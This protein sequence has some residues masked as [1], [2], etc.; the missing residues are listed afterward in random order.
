[1]S[2]EPKI[3]QSMTAHVNGGNKFS[4]LHYDIF[5]DGKPTGISRFV[6]TDG[7]PDY[8]IVSD[9]FFKGEESFDV[10][11]MKSVGLNQW[12]LDRVPAVAEGGT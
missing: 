9:I 4:E 8:M 2:E 11:A 12:I 1:M 10:M 7:K 6:K 5:A 3:T